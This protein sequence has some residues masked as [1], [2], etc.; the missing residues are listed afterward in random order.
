MLRVWLIPAVG[1][2]ASFLLVVP[3]QAAPASGSLDAL[4]ML[5]VE[6]SNVEET[7]WRGH[8]RCYRR[9]WRSHWGWRCRRVCRGR[10]W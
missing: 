5:G 1:V 7:H 10:R 2:L 8:R 4:R 3:A 9:C 6:Q